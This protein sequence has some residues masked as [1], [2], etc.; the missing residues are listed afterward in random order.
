MAIKAT[1]RYDSESSQ[2]ATMAAV[3]RSGEKGDRIEHLEM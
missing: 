1:G 2:E 3:A